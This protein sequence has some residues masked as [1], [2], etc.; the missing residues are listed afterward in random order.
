MTTSPD[1]LTHARSFRF[2][3]QQGRTLA[4]AE[5]LAGGFVRLVRGASSTSSPNNQAGAMWFAEL[6]PVAEGF[7]VEFEFRLSDAMLHCRVASPTQV[8]QL[9][10]QVFL[11]FNDQPSELFASRRR[12]LCLCDPVI[13]QFCPRRILRKFGIWGDKEF[14]GG[15][16]RH[17]V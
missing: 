16:V 15:G 9:R 11:L 2:E 6:L 17:L 13:E 12:R 10:D 7:I 3:N 5:T 14:R 8:R 4:N 1:L